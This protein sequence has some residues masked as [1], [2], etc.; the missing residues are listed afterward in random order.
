MI[1][2]TKPNDPLESIASQSALPPMS[3]LVRISARSKRPRL[4][5]VASS[6]REMA[7][8]Q[9]VAESL[10]IQQE[11]LG[12]WGVRRVDEARHGYYLNFSSANPAIFKNPGLTV[13]YQ[14]D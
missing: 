12:T 7:G 8:Y 11:R 13:A 2:G 3:R 10:P 14:L 1:D 5:R 6:K 9:L 4:G